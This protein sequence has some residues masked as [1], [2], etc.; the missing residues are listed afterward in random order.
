[1][2]IGII[3]GIVF[4]FLLGKAILETIWGSCLIVCGV[5]CQIL[6][7]M[8]YTI[9]YGLR[10][11]DKLK[12]TS[13]RQT[14]S[15]TTLT[16]SCKLWA[17]RITLTALGITLFGS[18]VFLTNYALSCSSEANWHACSELIHAVNDIGI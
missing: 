3:I 8:L 1:M 6:A 15:R 11:V 13:K 5:F 10:T 12:T 4:F 7:H 18:V 2:L 16:N 14:T 17:A 9:A